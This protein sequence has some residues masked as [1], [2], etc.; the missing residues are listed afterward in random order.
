M[1]AGESAKACEHEACLHLSLVL[2]TSNLQSGVFHICFMFMLSSCL[3]EFDLNEKKINKL[4]G[5]EKSH[6]SNKYMKYAYCF[7][8]TLGYNRV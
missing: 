4:G 5:G 6:L 2:K 3:Y 7:V 8:V 1:K